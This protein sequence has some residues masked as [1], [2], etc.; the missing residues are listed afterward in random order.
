MNDF[1]N[2]NYSYRIEASLNKIRRE[3]K[4]L[5]QSK[6][7]SDHF[8]LPKSYLD[9]GENTMKDK[10]VTHVQS[11]INITLDND[12]LNIKSNFNVLENKVTRLNS[13]FQYSD[14]LKF[15]DDLVTPK[16]KR[17]DYDVDVELYKDSNFFNNSIREDKLELQLK[18]TKMKLSTYLNTSN[19]NRLDVSNLLS[20][21]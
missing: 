14:K 7:I 19:S 5:Y 6:K 13:L 9:V 21:R 10:Y 16:T 2:M 11:N 8:K 18:R 4:S 12:L 3:N 17:T 1:K 15:K 20:T